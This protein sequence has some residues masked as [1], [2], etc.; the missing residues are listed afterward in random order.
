MNQSTRIRMY[1]EYKNHP[2]NKEY[3]KEK[4]RIKKKKIPISGYIKIMIGI[5]PYIMIFVYGYMFFACDLNALFGL[6]DWVGM[7]LMIILGGVNLLV[8]LG[9]FYLFCEYGVGAKETDEF[10]KLKEKYEA[11]GLVEVDCPF[12]T[13]C[14]EY[15]EKQDCYVCSVNRQP[16]SLSEKNWCENNCRYCARFIRAM[17]FDPESSIYEIKKWD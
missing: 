3:E 8:C 7:F 10:N 4:A 5:I 15:D 12:S 16:L 17:G 14:G 1:L 6:G 13:K 2:L 11:K 9:V